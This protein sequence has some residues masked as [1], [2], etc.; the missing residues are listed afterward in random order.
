VAV[1]DTYTLSDGVALEWRGGEIRK[2]FSFPQIFHLLL[3][4]ADG[5]GVAI[6]AAYLY[7]KLKGRNVKLRIDRLEVEIEEGTIKK[8]LTERIEQD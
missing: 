7:D 8:V 4:V 5:V 2:A 1:G 6:A 3:Q